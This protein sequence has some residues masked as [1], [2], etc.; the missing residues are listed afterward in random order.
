M[1]EVRGIGSNKFSQKFRDYI[2]DCGETLIDREDIGLWIFA[3]YPLE[4]SEQGA[5]ALFY[6]GALPTTDTRRFIYFRQGNVFIG[7]A[8][9][10]MDAKTLLKSLE[11]TLKRYEELREKVNKFARNQKLY[12]RRCTKIFGGIRDTLKFIVR[13]IESKKAI[14]D[15]YCGYCRKHLLRLHLYWRRR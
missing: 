10:Y 3:S 14:V 8:D 7:E 11:E 15:V 5:D 6:E 12:C 1:V 2:F 4:E 13:G 9:Y